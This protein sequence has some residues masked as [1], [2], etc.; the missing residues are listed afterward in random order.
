MFKVWKSAVLISVLFTWPLQQTFAASI[1]AEEYSKYGDVTGNGVKDQV[2]LRATPI[3]KLDDSYKKISLQVKFGGKKRVWA[4]GEGR[5]P[6]LTIEDVTND[7]IKDVL[8]TMKSLT[9]RGSVTGTVITFT[10]GK[11]H[12][13]KLPEAIPIEAF[14]KD[15]YSAEVNAGRK[16]F[17]IDLKTRKDTY[18]KLGMYS[19][20]KLNEP[21]ELIVSEFKSLK[22][23]YINSD[24]GLVSKQLISGFRREEVLGELTTYWVYSKDGWTVKNILFSDEGIKG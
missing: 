15:H 8:V 4:L 18:E 16:K 12:Q 24:K 14:F 6:V 23:Q 22:P 20:G 1:G 9:E 2:I 5:H 10:N 11:G 13:L 7:G 17:E 21:I 19:K 3:K